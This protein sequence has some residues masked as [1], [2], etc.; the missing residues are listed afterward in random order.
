MPKTTQDACTGTR[1]AEKGTK[2]TRETGANANSTSHGQI[3]C[4]EVRAQPP[5]PGQAVAGYPLPPRGRRGP[6]TPGASGPRGSSRRTRTPGPPE[7]PRA[8]QGASGVEEGAKGNAGERNRTPEST[9]P[10]RGKS[11]IR[12]GS[13][14]EP[15]PVRRGQVPFPFRS[16][17]VRV[18]SGFR[19]VP[20]RFSSGSPR[21]V[22]PLRLW[23]EVCG[24]VSKP[25]VSRG[26]GGIVPPCW[27]GYMSNPGRTVPLVRG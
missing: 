3:F 19:P 15:D 23:P 2:Q 18:P 5:G 7:Q 4:G 17:S 6:W 9:V 11:Y 27:D 20:S 16:R 8:P 10:L 13:R 24:G 12:F 14:G 22:R 26:T 21:L 1:R 25:A